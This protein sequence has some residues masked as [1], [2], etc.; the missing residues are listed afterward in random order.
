M[1]KSKRNCSVRKILEC[2]LLIQISTY[3]S[4][5]ILDQNKELAASN[6]IK[7]RKQN[8]PTDSTYNIYHANLATAKYHVVLTKT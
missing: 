8:S 3:G 4:W 7:R 2:N 6:R 5:K 1:I